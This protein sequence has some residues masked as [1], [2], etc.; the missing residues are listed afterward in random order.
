[1]IVESGPAAGVVALTALQEGG[2]LGDDVLSFEMGGTTAKLCFLSRGKPHVT[3]DLEIARAQRFKPGS[4]LPV[5]HPSVDLLE[6]GAGGGSIAAVGPD[7]LLRVGPRSTGAFPGPACYGLGGVE[8]T[9]TDANLVLGYLLPS[10]LGPDLP[11]DAGLAASVIVGELGALGLGPREAASAIHRVV[12]ENMAQAARIAAAERSADVR[13]YQLVAYGGAGPMHAAAVARILGIDQVVVPSHAGVLSSLGCLL[14]PRSASVIT[15]V[16]RPLG[17]V[18][19]QPVESSLSKLA[20]DVTVPGG[21]RGFAAQAVTLLAEMRYRGQQRNR[22]HVP[23]PCSIV[24]AL[25]LGSPVE[26]ADVA[27]LGKAFETAY[28]EYFGR[29]VPGGVIEVVSVTISLTRSSTVHLPPSAPAAPPLSHSSSDERVDMYFEGWGL[30][31][32]RVLPRAEVPE[33]GLPG[34]ALVVDPDTTIVVPPDFSVALIGGLV[35]M[36][37]SGGEPK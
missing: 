34:P 27:E 29:L 11:L 7:G 9:V 36:T 4:G 26:S 14:A 30:C 28:S 19:W 6:I 20:S 31:A 21:D 23:V 17:E 3:R 8:P 1:M 5:A 22:V 15:P 16:R 10:S 35:V 24:D 12:V 32:G 18:D 2:Q 33:G 25:T 37:A 13:S